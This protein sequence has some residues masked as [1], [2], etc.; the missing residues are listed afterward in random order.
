MAPSSNKQLAFGLAPLAFVVMGLATLAC[1]AI[2]AE[3][4]DTVYLF[5]AVAAFGLAA[6][7][8]QWRYRKRLI[9]EGG[10]GRNTLLVQLYGMVILTAVCAVPGILLGRALAGTDIWTGH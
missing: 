3:R 4:L 1:G 2:S 10:A 7:G 5:Y 9:A 6:G 8:L